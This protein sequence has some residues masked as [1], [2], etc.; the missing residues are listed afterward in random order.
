MRGKYNIT[1]NTA[2]AENASCKRQTD[3][4]EAEVVVLYVNTQH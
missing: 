3:R 4:N 2:E 1:A